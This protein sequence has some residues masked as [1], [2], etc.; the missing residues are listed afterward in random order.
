[1]GSIEEIE[2]TADWS[3]RVRGDDL[4]ELFH[5]AALGMAQLVADVDAVEPEIERRVELE[6]YDTESLLVSWL[7]ELLWFSEET[8]AIF[9]RFDIQRLSGTQLTALVRGGPASSQVKHIKAV[10]FHGL[11]IAE[12]DDGYEVTLVFDV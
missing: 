8:D 7:S 2:H 9:V 5:N 4:R 3:I 1:M 6:E 10:T 11:E 12:T